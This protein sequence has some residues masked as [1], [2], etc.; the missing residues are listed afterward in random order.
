VNIAVA[1]GKGGTGKTTVAVNLAAHLLGAGHEPVLVDCD[2]EE[3]NAHLF[4]DVG[5]QETESVSCPVPEVD[6]AACADYCAGKDQCGLCVELCRFKAL[7]RMAGEVMVFPELCHGCGLCL[8]ACPAR[9]LTESS[10]DLGVVR[11]GLGRDGM[12]HVGGLLRVGEAM[13]TPLI[14][15]VKSR[16]SAG[17]PQLWDCPPGTSCPVIASLNGADF[18]VLVTEPTAFG[19][20]DLRLAVD[21][22][23]DLG[24]PCGVVINRA[25]MGDGRVND[26]LEAENVP[27]LGELPHS[28]EAA[29]AC[30][31]GELLAGNIPGM[32]TALDSIWARVTALAGRE[33]DA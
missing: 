24:I 9:A 16:A 33:V 23:R 8:E 25:G 21:L 1:S 11:K 10:R 32:D 29:R 3:P 13:A 28:L 5:W 27:L 7:I 20:H 15:E 4:L 17:A 6:A 2:V 18:A 19:L 30:S 26:Y 22:A 14:R 12:T 31:R